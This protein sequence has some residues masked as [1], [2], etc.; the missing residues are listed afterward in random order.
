M[1][2]QVLSELERVSNKDRPLNPIVGFIIA[3][4]FPI[5][6]I[7]IWINK[8]NKH[9]ERTKK[10]YKDLIEL[11]VLKGYKDASE[12]E[13]MRDVLDEM[14]MYERPKNPWTWF[15]LGLIAVIGIIPLLGTFYTAI[16]LRNINK[17]LLEHESREVR[18]W[19]A[20]NRIMDRLGKGRVVFVPQVKVRNTLLYLTLSL[21]TGG[22]FTYYWLYAINSDMT[23]HFKEH[24]MREK[25]LLPELKEAFE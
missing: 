5:A 19:R 20:M 7:P 13:I 14:E 3:L 21:L 15:L 4:F 6:L 2:S 25:E 17:D 18:M 11:F 24:M 10:F 9:F 12:L 8:R 23:T 22:L 1:S 16:A